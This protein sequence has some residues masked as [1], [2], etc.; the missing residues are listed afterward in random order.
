MKYS[1]DPVI[2]RM[3]RPAR[4]VEASVL[5]AAGAAL[6]T[7]ACVP[8]RGPGVKR[9]EKLGGRRATTVDTTPAR[10]AQ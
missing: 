7:G 1:F 3:P 6:V 2:E 5:L 8:G 4:R 10:P 9:R